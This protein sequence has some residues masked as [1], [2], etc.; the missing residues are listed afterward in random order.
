MKTDAQPEYDHP[1]DPVE[2]AL[3]H[4][5]NAE[6]DLEKAHEEDRRAEEELREATEELDHAEH[7]HP[8]ETE[9]IVNARPRTVRGDE[10]FFEEVVELAFAG[11]HTDPNV[12]Y[13]MTYR[14]AASDPSAG[15]LARGGKV[16]VKNGTIF[17]VT[18]TN[19]S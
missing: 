11:P 1:S 16:K 14:Q 8:R 5:Q 13:S 15:E 9:I 17:N 12:V 18:K 19:R 10:V 6:Q 7:T 2:R 4:I 3:E